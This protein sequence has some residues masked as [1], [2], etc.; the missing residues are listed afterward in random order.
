MMNIYG[1]KKG[2]DHLMEMKEVTMQCN[3]KELNEII[4]FLCYVRDEW[5]CLDGDTVDS[6]SHFRDWKVDWEKENGDLIVALHQ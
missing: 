3:P 2:A 6:Y 1:Y 4:L 5:A